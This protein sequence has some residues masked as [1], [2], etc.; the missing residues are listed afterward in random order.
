MTALLCVCS[1]VSNESLFCCNLL[2]FSYSFNYPGPGTGISGGGAV[3][4]PAGTGTVGTGS[5]A[6]G[7]TTGTGGLLRSQPQPGADMYDYIGGVSSSGDLLARQE[8]LYQ[9]VSV[10]VIVLG[11]QRCTCTLHCTSD[12]WA[13]HTQYLGLRHAD[14]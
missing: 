10:C 3:V 1:C 9:Q 7:V 6:G 13:V 5:V 14:M 11:I 8:Q 2:L 12:S 4:P